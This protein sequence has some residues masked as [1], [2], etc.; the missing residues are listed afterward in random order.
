MHIVVPERLQCLDLTLLLLAF[1]PGYV[2]QAYVDGPVRVQALVPAGSGEPGGK[3]GAVGWSERMPHSHSAARR[4]RRR[5]RAR[6]VMVGH[7]G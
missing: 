1:L 4:S 5:A 6:H 7:T 3:S 2:G